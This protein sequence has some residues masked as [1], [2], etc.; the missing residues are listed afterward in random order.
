VLGH[1]AAKSSTAATVPAPAV[2]LESSVASEPGSPAVGAAAHQP[3][4]SCTDPMALCLPTADSSVADA[5]PPDAIE[6]SVCGDGSGAVSLEEFLA[7]RVTFEHWSMHPELLYQPNLVVRCFRV[8]KE[9]ERERE[10]ERAKNKNSEG[11]SAAI[12]FLSLFIHHPHDCC[13]TPWP[14]LVCWCVDPPQ[15]RLG[16]QLF[17]GRVALPLLLSYFAF[18]KPLPDRTLRKLA[19]PSGGHPLT[20]SSIPTSLSVTIPA[21][22]TSSTGT[23][24]ASQSVTSLT[25]TQSEGIGS[26]GG[27]A[28][29]SNSLGNSQMSTESRSILSWFTGSSKKKSSKL[30][31]DAANLAPDV[32]AAAATGS[33]TAAALTN[34]SI[35]PGELALSPLKAS[36]ASGMSGSRSASAPPT[37][38]N[39]TS[40]P[41]RESQPADAVSIAEAAVATV[42]RRSLRPTSHMLRAFGLQ[43]GYNEIIYSVSSALQGKQTISASIFVWKP[44]TKIVISDIDGTITKSDV[45]GNVM[46]LIGRDWSHAGV[47]QLFSN[48]AKNDF[49]FVYL[50][51]RS[52]GQAAVTRTYIQDLKQV[53]FMLPYGPIVM[54]PDSLFT[55]FK[56][57]V[58][59]RKPQEFKIGALREVQQLFAKDYN[60]FYAGFGN[61]DTDDISYRAV[62]IHPNKI[63]IINPRSEITQVDDALQVVSE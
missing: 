19:R 36:D 52:I 58:V 53:E 28:G 41:D 55:A 27:D 34:T 32:P 35:T 57:E 54:C 60:P 22:P 7:G 59:D 23:N 10:R 2:V 17:P 18:G 4:V 47:T 8:L 9:R 61:R 14:V 11:P 37:A 45:M 56:R 63:F 50:T 20:A 44:D 42:Q 26:G 13:I 30:D 16:D 3:L 46:P 21:G 1:T 48:I 62:G 5:L 6:M 25:G 29:S 39:S 31:G 51:S 12:C 38:P 24:M 33:A 43:D 15:I 40:K 49:E